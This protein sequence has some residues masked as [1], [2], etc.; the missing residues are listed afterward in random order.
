MLPVLLPLLI[1]VSGTTSDED[2]AGRISEELLGCFLRFESDSCLK[3]RLEGNVESPY[4]VHSKSSGSFREMTVCE[5]S[6]SKSAR[7]GSLNSIALEF[8]YLPALQQLLFL[9]LGEALL[10][11][12]RWSFYR[13]KFVGRL[14][15]ALI[16]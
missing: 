13:H 1:S 3:F 4:C 8:G 12:G 16:A 14:F 5:D 11:P 6:S 10:F 9:V 15:V 2:V 7:S